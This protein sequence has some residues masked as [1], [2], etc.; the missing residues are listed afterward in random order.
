MNI[1]TFYAATKNRS[2]RELFGRVEQE[3]L[4]LTLRRTQSTTLRQR[5]LYLH[6]IHDERVNMEK[7]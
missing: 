2:E 3:L 4:D 5:N 7:R 1:Q 6:K